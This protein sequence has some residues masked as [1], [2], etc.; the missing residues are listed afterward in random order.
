M[1]NEPKQMPL[2]E[3]APTPDRSPAHQRCPGCGAT[4]YGYA[5]GCDVC[6]AKLEEARQADAEDEAYRQHQDDVRRGY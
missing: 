3:D 4:G 6:E 5:T 2:I 1:T